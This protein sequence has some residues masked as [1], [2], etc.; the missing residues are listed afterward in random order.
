MESFVNRRLAAALL[1]AS[2]GAAAQTVCK[3]SA[4]AFPFGTYDTLLATAT[5]SLFN[6]LVRCDR[7]G[8]PSNVT[9]TLAVGP[10]SHAST[11]DAR[12]M[13][14]GTVAGN[15]LSYGLFTDGAY[16]TPVGT[17]QGVNTLSQRL[18]IPNRSSVTATFTL[19]GRIPAGQNVRAGSYSD[20]VQ[21]T[22]AP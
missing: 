14:H 15:Y 16:L 17:S 12:R 11:P 4:G 18:T 2:C 1:L 20:S 8:G 19:Y 13:Q 21:V 3:I 22:V 10:G 6:I 9:V 7:D 5:T